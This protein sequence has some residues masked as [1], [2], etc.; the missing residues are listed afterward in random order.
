M[1]VINHESIDPEVHC[2]GIQDRI[3]ALCETN[4]F[5]PL[6][7]NIPL[8]PVLDQLIHQDDVSVRR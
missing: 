5:W 7:T 6:M 1:L 2:T 3:E 8:A 4:D